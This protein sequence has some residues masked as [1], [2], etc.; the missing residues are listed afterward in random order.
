[1][2]SML[3]SLQSIIGRFQTRSAIGRFSNATESFTA[4][5][6][7]GLTSFLILNVLKAKIFQNKFLER[8]NTSQT[9]TEKRKTPFFCIPKGLSSKQKIF[10]MS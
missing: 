3:K 1:M 9:L 6:K 8:H 7:D 10:F 4:K 2:Q 5:E